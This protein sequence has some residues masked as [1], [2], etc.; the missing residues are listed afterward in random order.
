MQLKMKKVNITYTLIHN[1]HGEELA[2]SPRV[3]PC[4][5]AA[6][7]GHTGTDCPPVRDSRQTLLFMEALTGQ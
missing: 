4:A 2:F 1:L 5:N 6:L 7:V 3:A